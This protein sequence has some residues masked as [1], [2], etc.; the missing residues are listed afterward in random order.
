VNSGYLDGEKKGKSREII[1]V[2]RD[3]MA[4]VPSSAEVVFVDFSHMEGTSE[5][6]C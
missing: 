1:R 6:V 5:I 3:F 2:G 4:F